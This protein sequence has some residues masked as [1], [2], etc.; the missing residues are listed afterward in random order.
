MLAPQAAGQV[1]IAQYKLWLVEAV[2]QRGEG[3]LAAVE[4]REVVLVA[5][6]SWRDLQTVLR[7]R[8]GSEPAGRVAQARRLAVLA[9]WAG[10]LDKSVDAWRHVLQGEAADAEAKEALKR[11]YRSTGKWNAVVDLL[12]REAEELPDTQV[13][14]K[15]AV[16]KEMVEIYRDQ[17]R[18]DVMVNTTYQSLLKVDPGNL[19]ALDALAEQLEKM[20]R[21]PDLVGVLQKRVELLETAAEKIALHKRL[22]NLF[23][24]RFS[25]QAEAIKAYE[26]VLELAPQDGE[27]IAYL[28]EMYEK[29]RDWEKLVDIHQREAELLPD[30]DARA[31][32]LTAVARL[33]V[34]KLKRS[35]RPTQLWER[36]LELRGEDAAAL[37]AL[38]DIHDKAKDWAALAR[39]LQRKVEL[40]SVPEREAELWEKLGRLYGERLR[41]QQ[42]AVQSW[43]RVLALAPDHSRAREA[44]KRAFIDSGDW[45][46]LTAHYAE[47]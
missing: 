43:Q 6:E 4:L 5:E 26:A 22:A 29:R 34:D 13:A 31:D 20:R 41:D 36:V 40:E 19:E 3:S 37:D 7:Q 23:A 8:F 46:A 2:R 47:R 24:E 9:E 33:A 1:P 28:K 17:L 44:L 42:A 18:L 35:N 39:I 45:D 25:N 14:A 16:Y 38:E 11:L 10:N 12:K 30:A 27:A 15:V 21:W 32:T